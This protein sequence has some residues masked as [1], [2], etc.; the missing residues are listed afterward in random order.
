MQKPCTTAVVELARVVRHKIAS[1][2]NDPNDAD[3]DE[4]LTIWGPNAAPFHTRQAEDAG[5]GPNGLPRPGTTTVPNDT[6][7]S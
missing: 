4:A 5:D 3:C 6:F 2:Y 1:E 7:L